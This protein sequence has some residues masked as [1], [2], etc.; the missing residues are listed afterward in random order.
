LK[1]LELL[2]DG[3]YHAAKDKKDRKFYSLHDKLCR[4]DV[5]QD[6]W[7]RVSA[8]GGSPGID[9]KSIEDIESY[10]VPRFL[11]EI[12][13]ELMKKEYIVPMVKRVYIPKQDGKQRPLG[14]PTVKDRVVQ[15]AVKS[16]I[17]PIFEA[18]FKDFSYAY[19]K[20]RSA[21]QASTEIY[22]YINYGYTKVVEI[23]IK[24]FFDH[25]DHEKMIFFVMK[26]IADPYV[27]K[28]IREWLR[29]GIVY[30][31]ETVY[32]SEGTPQ[33]G[34][35]S[36]LLAN[37]YLNEMDTLW[38][39][40][41]DVQSARMIRYADDITILAKNKPE[42]Y[43]DLIKR[44]LDLLK[45]ELNMDKS[46]ITDVAKGFDF[47]G[48]HYQRR[49]SSLQKKEV[50]KMYP[51]RRSME[52]FREKVKEIAKLTKTHAKT[53]DDLISELN[54]LIRGYTN[55]FNHTNATLQYKSLY[56][57]VEWKVSKFYCD[58]HKIPRVSDRNLYIGIGKLS[59]LMQMTGRISYI[60]NAAR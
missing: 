35:I 33:G 32:P 26:R 19:R 44:I 17:E 58:L 59:G 11:N 51:S 10:G 55:Y 12:Q 43:I 2:Q 37:I 8:N 22:R 42:K 40:K 29:A 57:F 23:D 48:I 39:K 21:K 14:I 60:H 16:I 13:H 30:E 41:V 34:V 47:L 36:P 24:G 4:L 53:M 31:G 38:S 49:Y 7:K 6:A 25:I 27:I 56:H 46:R 50:I 3:L 5:L 20:G 52:K 1:T 15:Q 9:R 18:D 54:A 28:L 45:L